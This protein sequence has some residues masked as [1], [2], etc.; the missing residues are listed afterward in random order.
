MR[1]M[2]Q[3]SLTQS[4]MASRITVFVALTALVSIAFGQAINSIEQLETVERMRT[5]VL[6]WSDV[7]SPPG[8][9]FDRNGA[10]FDILTKLAVF[11]DL[12]KTITTTP[13]ITVFAPNDA[14]FARLARAITPYRG[15][16][17]KR[18]FD[19]LVAA[20]TTGIRVKGTVVKGK[21]LVAAILTYHVSQYRIPSR[22]VLGHPALISTLSKNYIISTGK[23]ELVDLSP[24]TPNP[25]VIKPDIKIRGR[26]IVH[27]IDFVLLPA[28]LELTKKCV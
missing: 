8:K 6:R 21:A 17:E 25:L 3:P 7:L 26:V 11:A 15:R 1:F 19:A 5:P 27:M 28:P 14:A 13:G 16:S 20:V 18:A 4:T 12:A 22:F 9:G 2:G 24:K 23:G 10:N